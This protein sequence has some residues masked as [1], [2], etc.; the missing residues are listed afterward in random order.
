[1]GFRLLRRAIVSNH[2]KKELLPRLSIAGAS[3]ERLSGSGSVW[4][5]SETGVESYHEPLSSGYSLSY[6]YST[7]NRSQ[8]HCVT[9]YYAPLPGLP[10]GSAGRTIVKDCRCQIR[11]DAMPTTGSSGYEPDEITSSPTCDLNFLYSSFTKAGLYFPI[12][13]IT[14]GL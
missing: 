11:T 7:S 1:M 12:S 13:L 10:E 4:Y 5:E 3:V 2:S 14:Y 9:P 8:G 6:H